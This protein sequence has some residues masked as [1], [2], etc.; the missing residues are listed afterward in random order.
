MG[1]MRMA[2]MRSASAC[3]SALVIATCLSASAFSMG[4][5][6]EHAHTVAIS[7]R[8]GQGLDRLAELLEQILHEG[9]RRVTFRIPNTEGGALNTLYTYATVEDVEYGIDEIVA[10]AVVDSKAHGM[11]REFDPTWRE[12][13]EE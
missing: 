13:E 1:E 6:A 4:V 3:A 11:L 2:A 7:A 10:T 8:T 9:K 12:K 5:P